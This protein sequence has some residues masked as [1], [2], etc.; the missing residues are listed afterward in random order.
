ML[1]HGVISIFS[2]CFSFF[3]FYSHLRVVNKFEQ[4]FYGKI[5]D[6]LFAAALGSDDLVAASH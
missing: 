6:W 1:L 2:Q 5:S 3:S 4:F